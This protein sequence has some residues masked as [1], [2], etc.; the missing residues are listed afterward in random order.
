[1]IMSEP[2]MSK[3]EMLLLNYYY[4]GISR[5]CCV[6]LWAISA[7][8]CSISLGAKYDCMSRQLSVLAISKKF[9]V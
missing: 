8:G 4:W 5:V 7:C 1:M 2:F 3:W 9:F 6:V